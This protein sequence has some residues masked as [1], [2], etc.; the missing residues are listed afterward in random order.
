MTPRA[1][2]RVFQGTYSEKAVIEVA[3][4]LQTEL[5]TNAAIGFL[6][7]TQEWHPHLEDTLELIRL[8]ARVPQIVG[9]SGWGIIGTRFELEQQPGFSLLL[10]ALPPESFEVL[11]LAEAQIES[12]DG[13]DFWPRETG[14]PADRVRSWLVLAN[15]YFGG[16][17]TW[18][19]EW[20]RAYPG[21][22]TLGGLA[23]ARGSEIILFQDSQAVSAPIVVVA[24]KGNVFVQPLVSQGC[25]PIG[26]PSPITRADDNL[27]LEIGNIPAYQALEAAFL[28]M[29]EKDRSLVRNNLFLG[30]AVS[31][32][33]DDFKRGDFLIRN[34]LGADPQI[35]AIAVGAY[36]RVGQTIQFQLRDSESAHEDLVLAA[37][38]VKSEAIHRFSALL[39]SCAGRGKNLFGRENHDANT[40]DEILGELPLAGFFCNGEIGPVGSRAFLHGYTASSAILCVD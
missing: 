18:L 11:S 6:F 7:V 39:F 2:S 10:L 31:E 25:R 33:I 32:Y 40:L 9:S 3:V 30:L 13:S 14:L 22:P 34:I 37:E 4:S 38:R 20:N 1:A 15:P 26:D 21:V 27:I 12:S 19:E 36:P 8:H 17:E 28:S 35:G 23:S 16:I 5:G 24:F 29:P